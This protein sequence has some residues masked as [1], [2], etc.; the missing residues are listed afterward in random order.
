ME[1]P[2]KMDDDRGTPIYGTPKVFMV[3]R[4][5]TDVL[6]VFA[7]VFFWFTQVAFGFAEVLIVSG[8][9]MFVFWVQTFRK[10]LGCASE[11]CTSPNEWA[12]LVIL[13][14]DAVSLW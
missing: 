1:N 2:V 5:F 6:L 7:E 8:F 11:P 14:R 12:Q 3:L 9:G 13:K 4:C 10:W